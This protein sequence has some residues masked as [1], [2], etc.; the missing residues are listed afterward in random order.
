MNQ[1]LYMWKI[2]LSAHHGHGTQQG[3]QMGIPGHH[4]RSDQGQSCCHGKDLHC[5]LNDTLNVEQLQSTVSYMKH[6]TLNDH[7]NSHLHSIPGRNSS[8][9]KFQITMQHSFTVHSTIYYC[10]TRSC[11][12][13]LS[14][15]ILEKL[16]V[17][18]FPAFYRTW[19]YIIVFTTAHHWSL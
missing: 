11:L 7:A 16:T 10:H 19:R 14:W 6:M 18:K 2:A 12:T 13:P 3:Q 8:H 17:K 1:L 9:L 4:L 5:K 15:V